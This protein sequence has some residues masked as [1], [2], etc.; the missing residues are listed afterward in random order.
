MATVK[1]M[2]KL[3][4]NWIFRLGLVAICALALA[5]IWLPWGKKMQAANHTPVHMTTDWSNRHMVFSSPSSVGQ[6]LTLQQEPRYMHQ[7]TRRAAPVTQLP[8]VQ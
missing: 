6:A 3:K 4:Q 2:T 7:W 1:I 5:G 8:A